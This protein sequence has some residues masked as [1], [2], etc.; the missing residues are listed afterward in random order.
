MPITTSVAWPCGQL[1][2]LTHLTHREV[3]IGAQLESRRMASSLSH[4]L[5]RGI[6]APSCH[7]GNKTRLRDYQYCPIG[8]PPLDPASNIGHR[9][10]SQL[11]SC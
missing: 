7:R 9:V 4:A 3:A 8:T 10:D 5:R 1:T 2:H 6:T 11:E